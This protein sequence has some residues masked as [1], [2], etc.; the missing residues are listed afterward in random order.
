MHFYSKLILIC[1]IIATEATAQDF[2]LIKPKRLKTGFV[3]LDS[4]RKIDAVIIHSSYC[5]SQSDSFNLDC[6]LQLYKN[7]DVSAH[8]IIDRAGIIYLLV[9]EK[10]ISHHAGKGFMPDGDNRP[11]S[12]SIGI[13]LINTLASQYTDNQYFALVSL[14]EKLKYEYAIAFV[15]GHSDI[16]PSRKT[17]PWNFDWQRFE[18]M[19]QK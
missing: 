10:N 6:I 16:A 15:L 18:K 14:I 19:M 1:L 11:N 2:V 12:R 5:P 13:E 17:D 8:Y 7:Y 3:A 9:D 4:V